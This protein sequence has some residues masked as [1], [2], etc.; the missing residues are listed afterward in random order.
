MRVISKVFHFLLFSIFCLMTTS[1]IS[2]NQLNSEEK[3]NVVST[4]IED[5]G[6]IKEMFKF[7]YKELKYVKN[8][9]NDKYFYG[10]LSP[11]NELQ[12]KILQCDVIL[13]QDGLEILICSLDSFN[14]IQK[15]IFFEKESSAKRIIEENSLI[16][17][18]FY[19]AKI[20][21]QKNILSSFFNKKSKSSSNSPL[22][23]E[24]EKITSTDAYYENFEPIIGEN[25][26]ENLIVGCPQVFNLIPDY[27]FEKTPNFQYVGNEYGFFVNIEK[28]VYENNLYKS[29][30]LLVLFDINIDVP[31]IL[32]GTQLHSKIENIFTYDFEYFSNKGYENWNNEF[33]NEQS[34]II[35]LTK[36]RDDIFI[37]DFKL[38]TQVHNKTRPNIGDEDYDVYKDEGDF[39]STA[40]LNFRGKN[41]LQ[42]NDNDNIEEGISTGV[43]I[44]TFCLGVFCE[45]LGK[46]LDFIELLFDLSNWLVSDSPGEETAGQREVV[47]YDNSENTDYGISSKETQIALYG[48]LLKDCFAAPKTASD[49]ILLLG[50]GGDYIELVNELIDNSNSI[51]TAPEEEAYFG[52]DFSIVQDLTSETKIEFKELSHVTD[53]VVSDSYNLNRDCFSLDNEF[54]YNVNF[55]LT[56]GETKFAEFDID[57]YS[58]TYK[59]LLSDAD[60]ELEVKYYRKEDENPAKLYTLLDFI[61]EN[62]NVMELQESLNTDNHYYLF[63]TNNST[64]TKDVSVTVTPY[65]HYKGNQ[66]ITISYKAAIGTYYGVSLEYKNVYHSA[67]MVLKKLGVNFT[68]SYGASQVKTYL[69]NIY[70][71]EFNVYQGGEYYLDLIGSQISNGIGFKIKSLSNVLTFGQLSFVEEWAPKIIGIIENPIIIVGPSITEIS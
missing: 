46:I 27:I 29:N 40:T 45:P 50:M 14:N 33:D 65:I 64:V 28:A 62:S 13:K 38:A 57:E 56:P 9:K 54:E 6:K 53:A 70:Q 1:T 4:K 44:A 8:E 48:H 68:N 42:F 69:N 16:S 36:E 41:K 15:N 58:G 5:A 34:S 18:D 2:I 63:V 20:E 17:N 10:L 71:T 22:D 52:F 39:F 37:K 12:I 61:T 49:E 67:Q 7:D 30:G 66:N 19:K 51:Q 55:N 47:D 60:L 25:K 11:L 32:G 43:S 26:N 23:E 35:C 3:V 31:I 24:L 21:R 59:Y